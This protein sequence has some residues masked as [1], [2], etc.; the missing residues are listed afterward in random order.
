MERQ[1]PGEFPLYPH[2]IEIPIPSIPRP[3]PSGRRC[4]EAWKSLVLSAPS[5]RANGGGEL[6]RAKW[7]K[8]PLMTICV[9]KLCFLGADRFSSRQDKLL[10][11]RSSSPVTVYVELPC[12]IQQG[13]LYAHHAPS[14]RTC[15]HY[16]H[17]LNDA[18]TLSLSYSVP[19]NRLGWFGRLGGGTTEPYTRL[20]GEER[21]DFIIV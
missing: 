12:T 10:G 16:M 13:R 8:K 18:E 7:Y 19:N 5:K 4:K 1:K 11:P 17:P 21:S 20:P 3:E 14:R 15:T 6:R 2:E 9:T